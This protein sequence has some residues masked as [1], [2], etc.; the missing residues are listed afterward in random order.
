MQSLSDLLRK[1][2][3]KPTDVVG[4][5]LG[6]SVVKAVRLRKSPANQLQVVAADV[7]SVDG[8]SSPPSTESVYALPAS[9]QMPARLRARYAALAIGSPRAVIKLLS[10]PGRFDASAEEKL[11]EN[12]GI[13]NPDK[14]R[15]SYKIAREGHARAESRVLAVGLPEEDAAAALA[16]F[17]AGIPAPCSLEI[18]GLAALSAFSYGPLASLNES[19][20]GVIEFGS[21]STFVAFFHKG[22]LALVRQFTVGADT[23]IER[24]RRDLGV[25]VPTA[26]GIVAD[27]AFD[28]SRQVLDIFSPLI[29]QLAVSRDFVERREDCRIARIFLSGGVMASRDV[30]EEIGN[31]MEIDVGF[32]NPFD[33]LTLA[34]G[35]IP[36][37]LRGKE[38]QMAGALGAA[39]ATME[40]A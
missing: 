16:L 36:D 20:V 2:R 34:H 31:T 6:S 26:R 7:L 12:L 4:L 18:S 37:S 14:C 28:I 8:A 1:M 3:R 32:W 40:E 27:G 15:V 5:D 35:A 21:A 33:G 38:W 17:A 19:S 29:K 13:E 30:V 25:D 9:L 39:L 23:V 22:G 24:V 11:A 10:F